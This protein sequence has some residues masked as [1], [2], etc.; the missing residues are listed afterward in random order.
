LCPARLP[1]APYHY[2]GDRGLSPAR[3]AP[4]IEKVE[5]A[6]AE[7]ARAE[8]A[9]AAKEFDAKVV[10]LV[11]QPRELP[12][13]GAILASHT[14]WHTA[15]GLLYSDALAGAGNALDLKVVQVPPKQVRAEAERALGRSAADLDGML[16]ALGKSLGPPWQKDHKEATLAALIALAGRP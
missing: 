6:V 12:D 10:A 14:L 13:L 11:A 3:A 9:R 8:V 16:G 5:T 2:V 7:M 4:H 1:R 15:E